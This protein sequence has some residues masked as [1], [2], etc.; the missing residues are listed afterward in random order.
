MKKK[1]STFF[2]YHREMLL[3]IR[4]TFHFLNS[5]FILCFIRGFQ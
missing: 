4:I 5:V 2:Q 3:N 1:N